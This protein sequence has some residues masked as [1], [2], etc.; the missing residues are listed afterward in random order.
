MTIK[1][2][3]CHSPIK[4]GTVKNLFWFQVFIRERSYYTAGITT[5]TNWNSR[6]IEDSLDQK[7]SRSAFKRK[8]SHYCYR[9]GKSAELHK[10]SNMSDAFPQSLESRYVHRPSSNLRCPCI[11][12]YSATEAVLEYCIMIVTLGFFVFLSLFL[13]FVYYH[14]GKSQN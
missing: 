7:I 1:T 6:T 10:M 14:F 9:K 3:C 12:E 4:S 5:F 11:R 8:N 2:S 13:K